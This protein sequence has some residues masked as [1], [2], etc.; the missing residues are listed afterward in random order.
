MS[1]LPD[2]KRGRLSAEEKAEIERLA[3]TLKKPT[4]G[5]IAQRLN[6]HPATVAWFMIRHGLIERTVKYGNRPVGTRANGTKINPYTPEQDR[7]LLELR[8][9]RLVF[10]EIAAILTTEFGVPRNMHSVQ[11]RCIMLAAYEGAEAA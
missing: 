10:R 6:R 4:P 3:G 2:I 9:Q 1:A 7:R 8:R 11:V 5:P